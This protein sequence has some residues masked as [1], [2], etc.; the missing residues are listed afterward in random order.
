METKGKGGRGRAKGV[1]IFPSPYVQAQ[2]KELAT[3]GQLAKTVPEVALALIG[4][5]LMELERDQL[6]GK[7]DMKETE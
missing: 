4:H 2:L 7:P 3:K 5:R 1:K 6:I